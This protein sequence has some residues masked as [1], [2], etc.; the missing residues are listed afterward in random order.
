MA[1]MSQS[2]DIPLVERRAS[3]NDNQDEQIAELRE[4]HALCLTNCH[5]FFPELVKKLLKNST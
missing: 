4:K 3:T 5:K 2:T 1:T